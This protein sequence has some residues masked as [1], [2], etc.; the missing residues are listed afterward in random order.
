M[1]PFFSGIDYY[2][3][4]LRIWFIN[5]NWSVTVYICIHTSFPHLHVYM[6]RQGKLIQSSCL[7]FKILYKWKTKNHSN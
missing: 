3:E 7:A 1:K 4:S 2:A 6:Q 5:I